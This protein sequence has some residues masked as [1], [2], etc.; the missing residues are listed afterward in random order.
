M[1]RAKND[2]RDVLEST[3][4]VMVNKSIVVKRRVAW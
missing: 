4:G 1:K 2:K 3:A